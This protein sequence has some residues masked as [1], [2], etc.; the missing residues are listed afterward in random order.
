MENAV[1][2]LEMAFAMLVFLMA[3]AL[4]LFLF[5]RVRQASEFVSLRTDAKYLEYV[6]E[7]GFGEGYSGEAAEGFSSKTRVARKVSVKDIV[8][9]LYNYS[10]EL[11]SV[12]I[13]FGS[14]G[15]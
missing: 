12:T 4:A 3:L 1:E 8:P 15:R 10:T 7:I 2:A 9:V 6:E 5:G 14:E 13:D 11:T